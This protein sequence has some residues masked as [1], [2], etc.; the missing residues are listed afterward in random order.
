MKML[1]S[2][3]R[4]HQFTFILSPSGVDDKLLLYTAA[5]NDDVT[6]EEI[7]LHL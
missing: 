7:D 4:V 3:C 1:R 2:A 5:L 6:L